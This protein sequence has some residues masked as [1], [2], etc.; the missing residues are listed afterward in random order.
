MLCRRV[1][2]LSSMATAII[3]AKIQ[4][5]RLNCYSPLSMRNA[6]TSRF[7]ARVTL[8]RLGQGSGDGLFEMLHGTLPFSRGEINGPSRP[9]LPTWLVTPRPTARS[10]S[11]GEKL[12][13]L[14]RWGPCWVARQCHPGARHKLRRPVC[15]ED[16]KCTM[17]Q[18]WPSIGACR[19]KKIRTRRRKRGHPAHAW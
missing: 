5:P 8:A 15:P 11:Q 17:A 4:R 10:P 1:P 12:L 19:K 18:G 2:E 6:Y 7:H 14:L 3:T 13:L 16:A 9:P